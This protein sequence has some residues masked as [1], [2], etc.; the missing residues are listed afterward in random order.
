MKTKPSS[1]L[2]LILIFSHTS[3]SGEEQPIQQTNK[4]FKPLF[5]GTNLDGWYLKVRTGGDLIANQVFAL[6]TGE[7]AT[8]GMMYTKKK[9]SKF[10]LKF[11]YKWG[12]RI[13]NNFKKWQYD[14]GVYYHVTDDA[15][16]P[17]GIEYQVRYNHIT[18]LNHTGD[19]I[20]PKGANYK[21]YG[22]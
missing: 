20:R 16:W 17:V 14:A 4:Q 18:K 11:E 12:T 15:I 6:N 10:H 2:C 22:H 3:S 13:A 1:L 19:A 9:F 7:N 21:W 8:H 5:N